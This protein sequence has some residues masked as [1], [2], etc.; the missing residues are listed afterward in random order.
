MSKKTI[1]ILTAIIT[2]IIVFIG[3]L[4]CQYEIDRNEISYNRGYTNGLLYTQKTGNIAYVN[5]GTL[6][7]RTLP[8]ICSILIEQQLNQQ[9][10]Q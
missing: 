3:Y 1:I 5:N 4:I 8:E 7:E 6:A 2:L 9:G 10:G